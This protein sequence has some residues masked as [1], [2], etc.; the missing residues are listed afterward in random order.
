MLRRVARDPSLRESSPLYHRATAEDDPY[1]RIKLVLR[2]YLSGFYKKPKVRR[3]CEKGRVS[4]KEFVNPPQ[5]GPTP[6]WHGRKPAIPSMAPD[7]E[8][9]RA[10]LFSSTAPNAGPH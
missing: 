9:W 4:A 6:P 10:T 2:W 3:L 5:E 1:S 7:P 8:R